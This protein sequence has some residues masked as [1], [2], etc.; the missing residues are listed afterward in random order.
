MKTNNWII[1]LACT[2]LMVI[3][4]CKKEK[5][6]DPRRCGEEIQLETPVLAKANCEYWYSDGEDELSFEIIGV[7]EHR[8]KGV[9]CEISWGGVAEVHFITRLNG[10]MTTTV[11][12]WL[13]CTPTHFEYEV[14]NNNMPSYRR[15]EYVLRLLRLSPASL[16]M[17]FGSEDPALEDYSF[18]MVLL[19]D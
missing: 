5:F 1:A 4:G 13:G 14:D 11:L 3:G 7:N 16:D 15:G 17:D 19:K 12:S 18:R 10:S 2:L 8:S 6:C 9:D